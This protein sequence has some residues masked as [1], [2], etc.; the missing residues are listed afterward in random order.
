VCFVFISTHSAE[1]HTHCRAELLKQDF[2][3]IADADLQGTFSV[4]G[5]LVGQLRGVQGPGPVAISQ[6]LALQ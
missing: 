3:I 6:R 1:L 5:I 4:D 2:E